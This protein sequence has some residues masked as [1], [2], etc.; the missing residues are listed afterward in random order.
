MAEIHNAIKYGTSALNAL[1]VVSG[2]SRDQS[3]TE[4]VSETLQPVLDIWTL[5]EW[6][7]LRDERLGAGRGFAPAVAG[8][9]GM[10]ALGN[11]AGSNAIVVIEA[12]SA[13]SSAALTIQ[14]EVVA[15]SLIAA[16]LSAQAFFVASRDRRILTQGRTFLRLGTDPGTTFGAQIEQQT[17]AAT[18]FVDFKNMPVILKPGDDLL[19]IGQGNNLSISANFKWRERQ[20]LPG[21]LPV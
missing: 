10:L 2:V 5:P 3:G 9:N 6:A 7:F 4:R 13:V 18:A 17:V 1:A 11:A 21:E 20:A 19:L 16:T 14:L 12:V 15:D 8:E